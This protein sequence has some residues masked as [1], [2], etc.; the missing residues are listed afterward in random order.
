MIVVV[1]SFIASL[2]PVF[3]IMGVCG[4][5]ISPWGLPLQKYYY[6][7]FLLLLS[8][9]TGLLIDSFMWAHDATIA[10]C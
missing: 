1:V 8:I 5:K 3:N 9:S 4:G 10:G 7:L 2:D 6:S